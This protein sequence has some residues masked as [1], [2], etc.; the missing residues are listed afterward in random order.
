MAVPVGERLAGT[1]RAACSM[2]SAGSVHSAVRGSWCQCK[3]RRSCRRGRGGGQG[4]VR[5]RQQ[6]TC[7]RPA[8]RGSAWGGWCP[9]ALRRTAT[10]AAARIRTLTTTAPRHVHCQT[11]HQV[12]GTP[13]HAPGPRTLPVPGRGRAEQKSHRI[14][15]KVHFACCAPSTLTSQWDL[16]SRRGIPAAV[17]QFARENCISAGFGTG[18][19]HAIA[20]ASR[21][22]RPRMPAVECLFGSG[23]GAEF[24]K[25]GEGKKGPGGSG[26]RTGMA[27]EEPGEL[28]GVH[29]VPVHH[30][31]CATPARRPSRT[32]S[33]SPA[34]QHS[35]EPPAARP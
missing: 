27:V 20:Q 13:G 2:R 33:R 22:G 31:P 19:V 35:A 9:A 6:R 26:R 4:G 23:R 10:P 18:S 25:T 5:Q 8:A 12:S 16:T 29:D 34:A 7:C 30:C 21:D 14:S 28:E 3:Q 11:R 15:P 17:P 1:S 24:S 32:E